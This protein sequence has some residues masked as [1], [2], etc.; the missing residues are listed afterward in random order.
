[1]DKKNT[2]IITGKKHTSGEA[3]IFL[4][5]RER[6]GPSYLKVELEGVDNE[7]VQ[8]ALI[9]KGYPVKDLSSF[10]LGTV[11]GEGLCIV[12]AAFSKSITVAHIEGGGKVDLKRKN[13]WKRSKEPKRKIKLISFTE[14]KVDGARYNI[15]ELLKN[16]EKKWPP[17]W[18]L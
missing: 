16:N 18:E 7:D 14:M 10:T 4:V 2:T 12:N 5:P 15:F 13:Y 9:S 8:Y 17:E 1:M 6:G 11:V 3:P